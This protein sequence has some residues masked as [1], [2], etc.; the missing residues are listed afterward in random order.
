MSEV[1][2]CLPTCKLFKC[3]KK[4]L[5][6]RGKLIWCQWAEERCEVKNCVYATCLKRKLLPSG[7]CGETVKRKTIEVEPEEVARLTVKLKGKA[8]RKIG[9][10]E[11]F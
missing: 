10:R 3:A 5:T 1:R 6:F 4:A 9:E 7:I 11:A 2:H 8:F